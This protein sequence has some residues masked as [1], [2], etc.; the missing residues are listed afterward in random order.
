MRLRDAATAVFTDPAPRIV[1]G[2]L[3]S[4]ASRVSANSLRLLRVHPRRRRNEEVRTH[5]RRPH[6]T[7][8][9]VGTSQSS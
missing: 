9:L 3:P 7:L 5:D 6:V 8:W 4:L 1:D 2:R